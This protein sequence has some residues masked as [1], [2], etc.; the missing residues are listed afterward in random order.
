MRIVWRICL[1]GDETWE[2]SLLNILS[3]HA[4]IWPSSREMPYKPDIYLVSRGIPQDFYRNHILKNGQAPILHISENFESFTKI[5]WR[6]MVFLFRQAIARALVQEEKSH[7]QAPLKFLQ[8]I[9]GKSESMLQLKERIVRYAVSP[10]PVLILGE[11]GVGKEMVANAL[12]RM[13]SRSDKPFIVQNC[14]AIPM[15]LAESEFWGS[16][17]GAYTGATDR[18]G[19][20]S[21]ADSGTLFLDE[22]GDLGLDIQVK[23]LRALETGDFRR[24]GSTQLHSAD[25]RL[26]SA[27]NRNLTQ[28]VTNQK[29]REDLFHRINV[30]E[31]HVPSLRSHRE[32]IP[33]LVTHFLP[34]QELTPAA[35]EFLMTYDWPGNVREF[36][37]RLEGASL[38]AGEANIDLIHLKKD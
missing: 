30:L 24:V 33:K 3:L 17:K 31:L 14:A 26:I 11:S 18:A 23:L 21:E 4:Q 8:E 20:F 29:F 15:T 37:N 7:Q 13:S 5:P 28:L 32:D 2:K 16:A 22:V 12:H 35:W 6:N 36:K 9:I 27:T 19:L 38:L 10:K 1:I 25:F 34:L